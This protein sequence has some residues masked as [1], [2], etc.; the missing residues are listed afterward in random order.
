[1][2]NCPL[3][4]ELG[5]S[6]FWLWDLQVHVHVRLFILGSD[7]A[8]PPLPP[9]SQAIWL[10]LLAGGV[11]GV[12][13]RTAT[14]PLEKVKIMAQVSTRSTRAAERPDQEVLNRVRVLCI[15]PPRPGGGPFSQIL[16]HM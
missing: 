8:P 13:S 4:N 12:V 5:A 16:T 2:D 3:S 7:L 1:M 14:A 15:S 6:R 10:A 9:A 11:A